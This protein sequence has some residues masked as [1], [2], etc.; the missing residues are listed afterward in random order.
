[1]HKHKCPECGLVWEHPNDG[2][3]TKKVY[4]EAH[5]CPG[6]GT[7]QREKYFGPQPVVVAH[8]TQYKP[9]EH[10]EG[11]GRLPVM[12]LLELLAG[13]IDVEELLERRE[14]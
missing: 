6:C 13:L 9:A 7:D 10:E 5:L 4:D 8:C 14:R 11:F 1:M 12:E 3:P 2:A